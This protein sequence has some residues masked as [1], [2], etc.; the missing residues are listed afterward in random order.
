MHLILP[1]C[2]PIPALFPPEEGL[3]VH[4]GGRVVR[5]G[6]ICGQVGRIFFHKTDRIDLYTILKLTWLRGAE[7][8]LE[9]G[10]ASGPAGEG[11]RVVVVEHRRH[12]Y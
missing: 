4:L 6:G 11:Q 8:E 12:H 5:H 9:R 2:G 3:V 10:Q 1:E 7:G